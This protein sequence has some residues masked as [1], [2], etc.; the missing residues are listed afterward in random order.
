MRVNDLITAMLRCNMSASIG[1]WC[2]FA[3][4]FVRRNID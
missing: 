1:I 4:T 3:S 2:D